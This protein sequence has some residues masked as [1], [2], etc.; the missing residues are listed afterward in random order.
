MPFVNYQRSRCAL[1]VSLTLTV[2]LV[3]GEMLFAQTRVGQ[4]PRDTASRHDGRRVGDRPRGDRN[5]PPGPAADQPPRQG[6]APRARRYS[7]DQ[8]ISH[9]AQLHTIAYNGLAFLSGDFPA[10]TFIPPGKVCDYFGFQYMR[11][12]DAAG[13]GHNPMFL[14]RVASN[15]L[16]ILDDRQKQLFADLAAE[17]GPQLVELA[18][19]RL[20]LIKAFHL[21]RDDLIPPG[22]DGL[23]RD[24]VIEHVG[25]IFARDAE[26]SLRRAEIM[27]QVELS[28][29]SDQKAYLEAMQFG[30]FN[31][32][33]E[34][35]PPPR[36]RPGGRR[37]GEF[38]GVGY[39]TYASEFF[40]WTA[41]S[42]EADTY[43]CPERHGT[44]FGGFFM[45]DIRAMGQRDYDISTSATGDG[46]RALLNEI[47]PPQQRAHITSIPDAQRDALVEIVSLRR[48]IATELRKFLVGETPDRERVVELGRRYGELDGAMSW[49]YAMAF[50]RINRTLTD[51]QR[52]RLAEQR[53]LD[54]YE[55]A[56][57]YI[58]SRGAVTPP[59][60][61]DVRRFFFAPAPP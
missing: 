19:M 14:G 37:H 58:Y 54:G 46:G 13:K 30:D 50:A 26:L 12:I 18:E 53:N 5:P 9:N 60:V 8:A 48:S 23:N 17:Q 61:G 51:Q 31:T 28:L 36:R 45:K 44:Y 21:Q 38:S 41:G 27:A 55:S 1:I 32:W 24:A 40:S 52:T 7:I 35:D 34:V 57:Y 22:S 10:A 3:A 15:V 29:T 56:P 4:P 6:R 59:D 39:M 16:H 25:K 2:C 20:P 47:L 43:F 49:H 11:D 42:L 33:P